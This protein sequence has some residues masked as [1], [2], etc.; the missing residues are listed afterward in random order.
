MADSSTFVT[1]IYN[2]V[3]T[4]FTSYETAVQ[5]G[6]TNIS[7]GPSG[8][9]IQQ[10]TAA[11]N[12]ALA[13]ISMDQLQTQTAITVPQ[14]TPTVNPTDAVAASAQTTV[15][16][17]EQY[18]AP[19][20]A[21]EADY[22][23]QLQDY[24]SQLSG[25]GGRGEAQLQAEQAAGLPQQRQQLANLQAQ[26]LAKVAEATKSNASYEQLI[27]N[28]ENPQNAQQQGIPMS[29]IIGQQA[30]VRKMQLADANNKSA[31]LGLLQAVA[32][33]LQ[34]NVQAMQENI[35]RS[36]DLRY[37]DRLDELNIKKQQLDLIRGQLD[38]EEARIAD[39][40]EKKYAADQQKLQ[41]EKAK[42]K[43]NLAMIVQQGIR[44]PYANLGGEIANAQTGQ[45]WASAANFQRDTGMT[46]D[47]AYQRGLVTDVSS[48]RIQ[49]SSILQ[50]WINQYPD[51]GITLQDTLQEAQS[52]VL[53]SRSYRKSISSGGGT[54]SERLLL[55]Q[56]SIISTYQS[57]LDQQRQSS[58]DH[59]ANPDTYRK[60][61]SDY[62][63][64]GGTPADF[65]QIFPLE[66]YIAPPN[67][68]GD[69]LG[70]ATEIKQ[71]TTA[72]NQSE[73]QSLLDLSNGGTDLSKLNLGQL[74]RLQALLGQ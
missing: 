60:A 38:K 17:L 71:G 22:N 5:N 28:L 25:T 40:W 1:G 63:A 36:V 8:T 15:Q 24:I 66:V 2:G 74:A 51:A 67:R 41:E 26:I 34:G 21:G 7:G 39:A 70:S 27:A 47:Q 59:F 44:T 14:Q 10:Q 23:K 19:M 57:Q 12:Q 62:V 46:V 43:N 31:D 20:A 33:G 69:L 35:N 64:S 29:A 61:K 54:V 65:F 32:S 56:K 72:A 13:P 37:Q 48:Q 50:N 4:T 73:L 11:A 42:A 52:K 49:E 9:T 6:A 58:T 68:Q 16:S 18:M 3:P 55:G 30:Q 53:G 45:G